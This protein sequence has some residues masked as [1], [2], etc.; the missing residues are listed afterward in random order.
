MM[1]PVTDLVNA[2]SV[3]HSKVLPCMAVPAAIAFGS[4]RLYKIADIPNWIP[5]PASSSSDCATARPTPTVHEADASKVFLCQMASQHLKLPLTRE[6]FPAHE[7]KPCF[8][9]LLYIRAWH[10]TRTR[11]YRGH[12]ALEI[13]G[14]IHVAIY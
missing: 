10:F 4:P 13:P 8:Q 6:N 2:Y 1:P 12:R 5:S 11:P 14:H 7:T 9:K 3:C